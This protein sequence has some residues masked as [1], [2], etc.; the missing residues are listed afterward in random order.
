MPQKNSEPVV[1]K[2]DS[3]KTI[4]QQQPR[5]MRCRRA[6]E[7]PLSRVQ[8]SG[9]SQS[10]SSSSPANDDSVARLGLFDFRL[11]GF[12]ARLLKSC[13]VGMRLN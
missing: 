9:T 8:Q 11:V 2:N 12:A 1:M 3:E 10:E 6:E 13:R 4:L 5:K 7:Q